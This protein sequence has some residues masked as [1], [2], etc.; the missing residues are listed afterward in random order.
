[1]ERNVKIGLIAD[2]HSNVAGLRWALTQLEAVDEVLC[3][4]DSLLQF[5]FSDEVVEL[6]R[7]R[8]VRAVLGN[9]ELT[10]LSHNGQRAFAAAQSRENQQFIESLPTTIDTRV[11]GKRLYMVHGSPWEPFREYMTPTNPRFTRVTELGADIVIVGHTHV[12]LVSRVG[13][14]IVINPGSCGEPRTHRE[15]TC[16]ILDLETG[17]IELRARSVDDPAEESTRLYLDV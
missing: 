4:G 12:P 17:A 10:L 11:N 13:D 9:H 3:A 15:W 6:L 1:M 16:A 14:T 5:R 8:Q 7:Q 2:I